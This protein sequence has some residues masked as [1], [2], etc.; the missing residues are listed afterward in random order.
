[1]RILLF[2][3]LETRVKAWKKRKN[4]TKSREAEIP[5]FIENKMNKKVFAKSFQMLIEF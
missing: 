5:D 2:I 1:M 3:G 4:L